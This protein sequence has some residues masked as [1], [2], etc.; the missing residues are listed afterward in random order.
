M[1]PAFA[2]LPY[3]TRGLPVSMLRMI[4]AAYSKL[5]S[6]FE[7]VAA[8]ETGPLRLPALDLRDATA[9]VLVERN[10]EPLD[11]VGPVALDEPGHVLGEVLTRLSDEV[12]EVP[13]HLVAHAI[14]L[15]HLTGICE[16][17]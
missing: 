2:T 15:G 12:A 10:V 9:R 4:V 11:Q 8:L 1:S 7:R 16:R 3:T 17:A 5:G 14:V 6:H 13:Q